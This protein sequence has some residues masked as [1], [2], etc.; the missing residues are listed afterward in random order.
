MQVGM[1]PGPYRFTVTKEGFAPGVS[2]IRIPLGDATELEAFKLQ[3][4][5]VAQ[6]GAGADEL[7]KKF[8]EAV[9]LQSAG[10]LDEAAALYKAILE[11]SPDV[12]EVHQNLG[13]IYSQKKDF[14][15]AE[16]EYQKALE[17]RPGSTDIAAALAGVYRESGQPDK[18]MALMTKA[19]GDN[20]SD[21]K[22]Q[23][24]KGI[25][26]LNANQSEEAVK[27][28]EAAVAADPTLRR[29]VLPPRHADGR[30]EQDPRGDHQPREVHQ[31]EPRRRAERGRRRRGCSRLSQEV[32]AD[33]V[34][35]VRERIARA[36]ERAARPAGEVT[37]VA[38]SK[39]HPGRPCARPSRP[40]C[41]TS[42][43]TA[44]RRPR[45][46]SRPRPTS[47]R[48]ACAGTSSATCSPTRRGARRRSSTSW[49]PSTLSTSGARLAREA[50]SAGRTLHVLV[51]VDLAGEETKFGL[52]EAQL[53]PALE[54]LRD[55]PGL[56]VEG[57]MVLPPYLDDPDAVRPFF[58]RLRALARPGAA[59]RGCSPGAS[60]RW[61]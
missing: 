17:L 56:R 9:Q 21:A 1:Q 55:A 37:L 57:L 44:C 12:P 16:A 29:G 34:A 11:T 2:E 22:A 8:S 32:I 6:G 59:A 45:Q 14:P 28:F 18:A 47:A 24:N 43:R 13:S 3:P 19:A 25:Y 42:A 51:Q 23:Y 4:A 26:L 33:R 35:A 54:A 58:R 40:A 60:C 5:T 38:V 48:P 7:K 61:A 31:P 50:A 49:S 30:A 20:P 10:K 27:A 15:A 36:A 41:A 39:T 46:R 53:F 52:E